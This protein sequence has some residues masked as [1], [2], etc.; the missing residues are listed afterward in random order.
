MKIRVPE[1]CGKAVKKI[2]ETPY[3]GG[4]Y[5]A[6]LLE[7]TEDDLEA[8]LGILKKMNKGRNKQA[9]IRRELDL[10]K[11]PGL[12]VGDVTKGWKENFIKEWNAVR[13]AAGATQKAAGENPFRKHIMDR[14]N[15]V[16]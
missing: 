1:G 9:E 11:H 6:L 7:Y 3:D 12:E 15:R 8:A 10:R 5:T 2:I 4:A 16:D 14:F 13:E